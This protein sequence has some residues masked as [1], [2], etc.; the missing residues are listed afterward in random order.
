MSGH[1]YRLDRNSGRSAHG[2]DEWRLK[3]PLSCHD[4]TG[5]QRFKHGG[6]AGNL[7]VTMLGQRVTGSINEYFCVFLFPIQID[8]GVVQLWSGVRSPRGLPADA[9]SD[10]IF[11]FYIHE[12]ITVD[13]EVI[14]VTRDRNISF[15]G[16]DFFPRIHNEHAIHFVGS[17]GTKLFERKQHLAGTTKIQIQADAIEHRPLKFDA[18]RKNALRY[19]TE[20]LQLLLQVN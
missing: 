10:G 16:N 12:Q 2:I 20:C 19:K 14:N 5:R 11:H 17:A 18:R 1:Q 6:L 13:C 3:V 8:Y 7:S 9:I 4:R 15:V